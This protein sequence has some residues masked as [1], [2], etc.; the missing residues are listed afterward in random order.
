MS[1]LN[2]KCIT[3]EILCQYL[4]KHQR[5]IPFDSNKLTLIETIT[6]YWIEKYN[7]SHEQQSQ[8]SI[9]AKNENLSLVCTYEEIEQFP[10]KEMATKFIKWFFDMY[11]SDSLKIEDFL[12]DATCTIELIDRQNIDQRL[13]NNGECVQELLKQIRSQYS[14]IYN[15]NTMNDGTQGRM[16]QHGLVFVVNCGTLHIENTAQCIG[17]YECSFGLL[18]DPFADNNWKIKYVKFRLRSS[19]TV[20]SDNVP[21]LNDCESLKDILA[22]PYNS[23]D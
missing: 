5:P 23:A 19:N 7:I 4:H 22:L 8:S 6:N 12:S 15:P 13:A 16:N 17:I 9:P 18:R 20:T 11:N 2:R 21:Q 1:I 10:I 14:F 3:K